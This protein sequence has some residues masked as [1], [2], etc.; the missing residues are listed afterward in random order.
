LPVTIFAF[1][2]IS[3][4]RYLFISNRQHAPPGGSP[5]RYILLSV[6]RI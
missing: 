1:T 4:S 6:F 5:P 3:P 2:P